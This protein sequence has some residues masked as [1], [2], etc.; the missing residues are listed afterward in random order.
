[1]EEDRQPTGELQVRTLAMPADANPNGDI[2]GGWVLSQMDIAGGIAA[3]SRSRGRVATVAVDAMT[4]KRPVSVG[5]V[6]CCYT[7]VQRIGTT[8][9][10]IRIEAWALRR[11]QSADH[12]HLDR[13]RVLVTEGTFTFVAINAGGSPRPVPDD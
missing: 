5:D 1:M 2:F 4:F 9:M 11:S 7:A 12:D 6:L 10:T 13:H 8:S 3:S